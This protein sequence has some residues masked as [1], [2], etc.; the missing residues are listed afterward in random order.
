MPLSVGVYE[1]IIWN[2]LEQIIAILKNKE[3]DLLGKYIKLD[4]GIIFL[5]IFLNFMIIAVK[6]LNYDGPPCFAIFSIY[7]R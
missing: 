5:E 4:T 6:C 2:T 1:N 7:L 3:M